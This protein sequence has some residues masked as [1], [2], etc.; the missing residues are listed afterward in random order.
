MSERPNILRSVLAAFGPEAGLGGRAQDQ[1]TRQQLRTL[2]AA[3]L[4]GSVV[5]DDLTDTQ[6]DEGL[7][8]LFRMVRPSPA[9]IAAARRR[10]TGD[11]RSL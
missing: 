5:A 2:R 9:H 8:T 11:R 4:G 3:G 10:V 6:M 1:I 7:K